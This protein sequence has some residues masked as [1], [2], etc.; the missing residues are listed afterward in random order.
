MWTA[1]MQLKI[2]PAMLLLLSLVSSITSSL[3]TEYSDVQIP[4]I[5]NHLSKNLLLFSSSTFCIAEVEVALSNVQPKLRELYRINGSIHQSYFGNFAVENS[6]SAVCLS[7]GMSDVLMKYPLP[8]QIW[9]MHSLTPGGISNDENMD[10]SEWLNRCQIVEVGFTSNIPKGVLV[11]FLNDHG[12]Y[13]RLDVIDENNFGTTWHQFKIGHTIILS[14]EETNEIL[15]EYI[16]EHDMVI[17][18]GEM[19]SAVNPQIDMTEEIKHTLNSEWEGSRKVKRTFTELGFSLSKLPKD[20]WG[21]MSTYYYNNKENENIEDWEGEGTYINWWESDV[22]IIEMPPSLKIYWQERLKAL[23]EQWSNTEL[24][25]TTIYGMR[26]YE[27]GAK[28]L[29]HVDHLNTHAV[30]LII[31]VGQGGIRKPWTLEIY[32]HAN[33]LHEVPMEEGDIIYY[34]SAKCLHGKLKPLEGAFYVNLFAHYRPIGDS[35]WY[36]KDNP[37]HGVLPLLDIQDCYIEK[38]IEDNNDIIHDY[39]KTNINYDLN[40]IREKLPYLSIDTKILTCS[41][42]LFENWIEINRISKSNNNLNDNDFNI[43]NNTQDNYD[44]IHDKEA[45]DLFHKSNHVFHDEDL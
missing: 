39:I 12:R 8:R 43:E 13:E 44:D 14:I 34:E 24:E 35:E 17:V 31:N 42:E 5:S 11:T 22:Y 15:G 36:E 7:K 28:L 18:V 2:C 29:P 4:V 32:D 1:E 25:L 19:K 30:S 40:C 27:D 45:L 20:L 9:R 21:S 38:K 16:I 6:C 3:I 26:K 41:Q 10:L 23:V 33:R 37:D